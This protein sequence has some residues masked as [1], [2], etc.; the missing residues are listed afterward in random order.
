MPTPLNSP[1]AVFVLLA[2]GTVLNVGDD[3]HAGKNNNS[4]TVAPGVNDD[5]SAGYG[6]GSRWNDVTGDAVYFCLD[7][8]VGVAI[9]TPDLASGGG[10]G[11]TD[12]DDDIETGTAA[13]ASGSYPAQGSA[14]GLDQNTVNLVTSVLTGDHWVIWRYE[15]TN[16][17]SSKP[18][19]ARCFNDTDDESLGDS[20][21]DSGNIDFGSNG[22]DSF[23]EQTGFKKVTFSGATKKF[24][25]QFRRDN[26]EGGT[27][28]IRRCRI[29]VRAVG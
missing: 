16:D 15:I 26:G 12:D 23:I 10:A 24:R 5:S 27:A 14:D 2:D 9:W 11:D 21:W 29:R 22:V 6:V 3:L 13:S 20:G 17:E 18:T 25:I 4:A 19:Y 8:A 1:V 7:P 28:R